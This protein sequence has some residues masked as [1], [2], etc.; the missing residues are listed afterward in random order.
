MR[1]EYA[2]EPRSYYTAT[3]PVGQ[4]LLPLEKAWT[5]LRLGAVGLGSGT[6]SAYGRAG[7]TIEFYELN[8]AIKRMAYDR[9]LFTYVT[10]SKAA[11]HVTL[12]DARLSLNSAPD[13]QYDVLILDAFSSDS[14]PV[15]LLTRE[16]YALYAKKLKPDGVLLVHTSNRFLRL[17]EVVIATAAKEGYIGDLALDTG[18]G[19]AY[20]HAATSWVA[21]SKSAASLKVIE[22]G[23]WKR[24]TPNSLAPVWTDD[25]SNVFKVLRFG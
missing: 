24:Q 15:H 3:G 18:D 2:K 17:S 22:G 9:K 1:P 7:D 10:D 12:G 8:P 11:I 5:P 13:G 20:F 25:Y 23:L 4:A 19:Q 16:A 14:I 21:L 6:I